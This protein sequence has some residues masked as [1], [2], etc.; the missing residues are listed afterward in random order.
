MVIYRTP[1]CG[2]GDVRSMGFC[3][4]CI[5]VVLLGTEDSLL[6]ESSFWLLAVS[7]WLCCTLDGRTQDA[8]LQDW[9]LRIGWLQDW[10]LRIICSCPI[11]MASKV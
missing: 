3:R 1:A 8:P 2:G 9:T 6:T 5:F 4:S 7:R 10:T 11:R